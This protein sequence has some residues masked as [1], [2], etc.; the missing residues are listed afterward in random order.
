MRSIY[1]VWAAGLLLKG[2]GATWDVAFHFR[3]LRETLSMPHVV[4]TIGGILCAYAFYVE[5]K[6]RDARRTG[7]LLVVLAG[8]GI[9]LFAMPFD[10]AWHMLFGVD[11]TTWSPAHL[12]LFGGTAVAVFGVLLLYATDL[13]Q[14][15][16]ASEAIRSATA[17]QRAMLAFFVVFFAAALYFPL[18]YN[19]Y[20]TVAAVTAV[21]SP[22]LMDPELVAA[23]L[24]AEDPVF[25]NTPKALYPAY[26]VAMA[27]FFATVVRLWLGR[28]WALVG[29]VGVAAERALADTVITALGQAGAALPFQFLAIGVAVE[30][31]FLLRVPEL[32]TALLAGAASTLAGY[33]YFVHPL[34]WKPPV[35][36]TAESWPIGLASALFA[37]L[38]AIALAG[39]GLRY[40]ATIPMFELRDVRAWIA[41]R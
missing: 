41:R 5:W 19:E 7:P 9:F 35:P 32:A 4:N 13:A 8:I 31:V 24:A 28:G 27:A 6:Q 22:E 10:Q 2:I 12:M 3:T 18:T 34:T 14:G 1:W 26:S 37:A 36:L 20:T 29:L 21:E 11:L 39:H 15:R 30:L 23:A 16:P 25:L 33:A 38:L 40:V 17:K